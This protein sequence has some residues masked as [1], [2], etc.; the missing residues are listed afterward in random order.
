MPNQA[1]AS[2][3][4][5]SSR[6]LRS[7]DLVR[8]FD[9]PQGLRGYWLTD[10]GRSCLSLRRVSFRFGETGIPRVISVQENRRLQPVANSASDA[11]STP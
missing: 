10:F 11:K 6:F 2:L 1:I 5:Y 7:T 9:D 8:D 3:H 4:N